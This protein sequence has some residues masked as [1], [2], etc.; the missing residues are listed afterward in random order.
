[1]ELPETIAE[2]QKHLKAYDNAHP[3]TSFISEPWFEMYLK[4]R[5][6]VPV[7]YNPFMM[8]APDPDPS[9]NDQV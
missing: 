1:M 5:T 3:D 9:F 7:N 8:F 6:P 2:L 4:S